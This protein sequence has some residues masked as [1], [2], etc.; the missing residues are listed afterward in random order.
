MSL[1]SWTPGAAD[2]AGAPYS[3]NVTFTDP[4]GASSTCAVTV[5]DVNLRP[6][7]TA[8]HQTLECA[9][10]LGA[11]VTLDGTATDADDAPAS[12]VYQWF[13]SDQGVL[14]DDPSSPTPTG[15]FPIGVTMATLTVVDGRGGVDVCDVVITV[16][17]TLPPEVLCTTDRAALWPPK[18]SMTSVTL[19]VAA[20]DACMD[21]GEIVPL[22]VLVSSNEPDDQTGGGDGHTSGDVNGFD[23]YLAPVDVTGAFSYDASTGLWTGTILLRAERAGDGVGR[24][25]TLDVHAFDSHGNAAVTS[26]C[27]IVPHDQRGSS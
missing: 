7:C 1:L 6:E 21:P 19:V 27:V 3:M 12:L 23:G 10:H 22:S 16:Q 15:V 5:A 18:H 17:D 20:T 14:L 11:L 4:S 8:S 25:Y 24:K 13:V 9:N 26:C 2:K